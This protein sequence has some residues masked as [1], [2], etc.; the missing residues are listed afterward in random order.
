GIAAARH[1]DP[2]LVR[3]Y[4]SDIVVAGILHATVGVVHQSGRGPPLLRRHLQRRYG[5]PG[6]QR[7]FQRPTQHAPRKRVQHHRQVHELLPQSDVS[8]IGPPELVDATYDQRCRQVRIHFQ[9][10]RGVGGRHKLTLAQAQQVIFAHQPLHAVA[11]DGQAATAQLRRDPAAAI[12]RPRQRHPL[13]LVAQLHRS[14]P[15]ATSA[16]VKSGATYSRQRAHPADRELRSGFHF[17]LDLLVNDAPPFAARSWRCCSTCCKA[18]FKKSISNTC[19]PILR[20]NSAI[21]VSSARFWP[22]PGNARSP[23]L[24]TSRLQRYSSWRLTSRLRATK[25]AGSPARNRCTAS[26]LNSLVNFLRDLIQFSLS[27]HFRAYPVV[28][29]QGSTPAA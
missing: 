29:A 17:P 22:T 14:G 19:C 4:P 28:S 16:P 24:S 18:R 15:S 3:L 11:I 6:F 2:D 23:N 7:G 5:Q 20:S 21:R 12:S 9:P 8:D 1:T 25:P 13:H 26:N 10:V 27:L